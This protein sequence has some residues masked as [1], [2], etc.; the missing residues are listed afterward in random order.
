[1]LV[2]MSVVHHEPVIF[3]IDCTEVPFD[4]NYAP[5][6]DAECTQ[7]GLLIICWCISVI[8][9]AKVDLRA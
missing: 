8:W 4:A 1:M 5:V 6:C 7:T 3:I 2:Y 9:S